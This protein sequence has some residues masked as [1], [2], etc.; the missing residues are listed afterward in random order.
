V[1][2]RFKRQL[3]LVSRHRAARSRRGPGTHSSWPVLNA[4]GHSRRVREPAGSGKTRASRPP[5]T[6]HCCSSCRPRS[7]CGRRTGS[8]SNCCS[9]S[10][11]AT[12]KGVTG[13]VRLP[14]GSM[15]ASAEGQIAGGGRTGRRETG[16]GAG[17]RCRR[18]RHARSMTEYAELPRLRRW[19]RR[20]PGRADR[21]S[22]CEGGGH[23]LRQAPALM[24]QS[25]PSLVL[26][27]G[28]AIA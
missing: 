8:S 2:C 12:R 22:G 1:G 16:R 21:A 7:C 9:R 26:R 5:G 14:L 20:E 15:W 19:C 3:S 23:S 4:L 10:R 18:A 13:P 24:V 28:I 11:R 6:R 27:Y 25:A 17:A